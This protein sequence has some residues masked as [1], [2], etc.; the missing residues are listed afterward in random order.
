APARHAF[1]VEARAGG[2]ARMRAVVD[3]RH[4][5]AR[6]ALTFAAGQQRTFL[7]HAFA[8]QPLARD[9]ENLGHHVRLQHDR[10]A[11]R[12]RGAGAE[13]R[14]RALPGRAPA[15]GKTELA[16]E[17]A[18]LPF[19]AQLLVVFELAHRHDVAV[20]DRGLVVQID[21]ARGQETPARPRF[22]VAG[23]AR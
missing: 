10:I 16:E 23:L 6:D 3:Q 14:P 13:H 5:V 7:G 17:M 12:R 1:T 18:P 22:A 20:H 15:G 11:T 8:E 19:P 21:A 4:Y 2:A 9:I